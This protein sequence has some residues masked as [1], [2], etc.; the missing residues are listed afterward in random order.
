MFAVANPP[1]ANAAQPAA[2]ADAGF[3]LKDAANRGYFVY[4]TV[5]RELL[6]PGG[7]DVAT[8]VARCAPDMTCTTLSEQTDPLRPADFELRADLTARL[9]IRWAGAPL[10]VEWRAGGAALLT[11]SGAAY[12]SN[13]TNHTEALVHYRL[14]NS[15]AVARLLGSRTACTDMT[16][17]TAVAMTGSSLTTSNATRPRAESLKELRP[18]QLRCAY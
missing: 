17:R 3:Y 1:S 16:A 8:E 6:P 4:V 11:T 13:H 5:R 14:L 18:G 7:L 9:K 12:A 10:L 2:L 15:R